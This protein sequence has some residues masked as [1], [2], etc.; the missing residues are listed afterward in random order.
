MISLPN[1]NHKFFIPKKSNIELLVGVAYLPLSYSRPTE[2]RHLDHE[3]A[4]MRI[5]MRQ[6]VRVGLLNHT[7]S[8]FDS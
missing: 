7:I 3:M 1:S 5:H 2:H 6:S 4:K 8:G